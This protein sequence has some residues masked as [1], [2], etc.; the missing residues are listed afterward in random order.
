MTPTEKLDRTAE[1]GVP[2]SRGVKSRQTATSFKVRA[3]KKRT[4]KY[5]GKADP[6]RDRRFGVTLPRPRKDPKKNLR[7][8]DTSSGKYL[9]KYRK[10]SEKS[11]NRQISK[12]ALFWPGKSAVPRHGRIRKNFVATYLSPRRGGGNWLHRA[13]RAPRR[14]GMRPK[15]AI[16][17]AS[18][19]QRKPGRNC[20]KRTKCKRRKRCRKILGQYETRLR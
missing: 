14:L 8:P 20:W 13:R 5:P 16:H 2:G 18:N 3:S 9:R 15:W 4:N 1:R 7:K 11:S 19:F 12:A 10:R 17:L 6:T